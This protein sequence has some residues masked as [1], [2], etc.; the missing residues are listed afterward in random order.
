VLLAP[1]LLEV[2][3]RHSARV[4]A[5]IPAGARSGGEPRRGRRAGLRS[6]RTWWLI[7]EP[8]GFLVAA[9]LRL[10]FRL[11]GRRDPRSVEGAAR[12]LGIAV[13]RLHAPRD[14]P[15]LLRH[16]KPDLVLNQSEIRLGAEALGVPRLGFLNRHASLLPRHRG[17]LASFRAHAGEPPEHGVTFHR[18]TEELDAGPVVLRAPVDDIDPCAP[19]PRV[20]ERLMEVAAERFG[21]AVERVAAAAGAPEGA[22]GASEGAAAFPEAAPAGRPARFPTLAEARRYRAVLA[23]RQ[24]RG[25]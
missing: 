11:L 5:V 9:A 6:L 16:L 3:R 19:Y 8:R 15:A 14:L 17:R 2:L 21:E 12:R 4:V 13:H 23:A 20:A 10:R 24:R 18:V 22:A 7:L 25:L 1:F